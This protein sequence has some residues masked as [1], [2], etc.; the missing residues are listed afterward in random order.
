[1][2]WERVDLLLQKLDQELQEG[3]FFS[4]KMRKQ[5]HV[6]RVNCMDCLDRTNV[7]QSV[8][9]K[10]VL[11]EM[12]FEADIIGLKE[13]LEIHGN[14]MRVFRNVWADNADAISVQ[15]S[16]TPALK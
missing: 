10:R 11:H 4:T 12:L 13:R 7:V 2:R 16:G 6:M 3:G 8:F 9:A 5:T 15:Y 1:M 14:L